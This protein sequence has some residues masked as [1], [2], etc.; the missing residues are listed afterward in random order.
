M[1]NRKKIAWLVSVLVDEDKRDAVLTELKNQG[2]DVRAFF[3][4]LSEMDIY[5]DYARE[6]SISTQISKMGRNL[7]TT[8]EI[9][10]E[11]IKNII[12]LINSVL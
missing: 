6:C 10:K 11:K 12:S 3:V 9:D 2:V 7:P 4:P 8:Y 5:K 1:A